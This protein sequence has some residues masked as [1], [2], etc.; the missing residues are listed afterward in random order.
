MNYIELLN[1]LLTQFNIICFK[2]CTYQTLCISGHRILLCS[3]NISLNDWCF[4][5]YFLNKSARTYEVF[6]IEK[7]G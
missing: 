1:P 7:H 4:L 2:W 5:F 6:V 3:K